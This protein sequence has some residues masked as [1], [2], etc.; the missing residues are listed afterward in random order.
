MI[1]NKFIR[2]GIMSAFMIFTLVSTTL[3]AEWQEVNGTWKYLKNDGTYANET[4]AQS[5]EDW[6][7]LDGNEIVTHESLVEH[8]DHLYYVD[9]SGKMVRNTWIS[10]SDP[11]D[12][13]NRIWYYFG[14]DGKAYKG[15]A[16]RVSL[17]EIDG[18]YYLFDTDGKMKTG[19]ISETGEALEDSENYAFLGARYY[20]GEDGAMYQNQW[21]QYDDTGRHGLYS[22][23]A[24][25]HYYEFDELWIYFDQKGK[26]VTA[27]DLSTAKLKEING[28]K[29]SFDENGVMIPRLFVTN[30]EVK[31]TSSNAVIRYG[32]NDHDGAAV[33]DYWTF[34]VPN[35]EMHEEDYHQQEFSW[36][37]T[38]KDGKVIKDRI[39]TVLGRKY[40]FDEIGRMQTGFV[41]MQP[42][43]TFGMQF[44]I[45]AFSS[46]DFKNGTL[47]ELIPLSERGNLYLFGTDEL[48]DGSMRIGG[49]VSVILSDG[50]ATIGVANNGIVYG[51][52]SKLQKVNQKYYINGLLLAAN[53]DLGYGI[54]IDN[55]V[56]GTAP[57]KYVVDTTGRVM[58]QKNAALKAADGSWIIVQNGKFIARVEDEDKPKWYT[59]GGH[60]GFWRVDSSLKGTDRY[61]EL[62]TSSTYGENYGEGFLIYS[63][64]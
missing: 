42:D 21:L 10:I 55:R 23:L 4:W 28:V 49:E 34:M 46:E 17:K 13:N 11:E 33:E 57:G 7:Y 19:F 1:R 32:S 14:N 62:I 26:M 24:Q 12:N 31:A 60:T 36:F 3:G 48:N 51:N 44:D 37:R 54:I 5:G 16:D 41:V 43:G 59:K 61:T 38:K 63:T 2:A 20:F 6:Y 18:K 56:S 58:K 53:T 29:Y 47:K 15:K 39:A 40:A 45:D 27:K 64:E 22:E 52:R 9:S 8:G 30:A 25:R 35:E 50:T